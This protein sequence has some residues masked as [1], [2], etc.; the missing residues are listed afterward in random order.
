MDE[1]A[2]LIRNHACSL[3][4]RDYSWFRGRVRRSIAPERGRIGSRA[5]FGVDGAYSGQMSIMKGRSL[6]SDF[7][8]SKSV[9]RIAYLAASPP[10]R[11]TSYQ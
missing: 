10:H 7:P 5:T 3:M 8:L 2:D 1:D 6:S 9:M 4:L 11:W